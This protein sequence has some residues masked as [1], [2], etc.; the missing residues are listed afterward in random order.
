MPDLKPIFEPPNEQWNPIFPANFYSVNMDAARKAT[1]WR[2]DWVTAT[3]YSV[4]DGI[5]IPSTNTNY[6]CAIAHTSGTFAT[7]LAAVKWVARHL[8]SEWYGRVASIM[9]Q[10]ISA[11]FSADRTKYDTCIG[12]QCFSTP[13]GANVAR[14]TAPEYVAEMGTT[15]V[16]PWRWATMSA[17]AKYVKSGYYGTA[18]ETDM[19]TE[20]AT[21]SA[22]RKLELEIEFMT[23]ESN[24]QQQEAW[25][26]V[27]AQMVLWADYL[28]PLGIASDIY[29]GGLETNQN[30]AVGTLG[31]FRNALKFNP[32]CKWL[33]AKHYKFFKSI[34]GDRY[35][36]YMF[37]GLQTWSLRDPDIY[38]AIHPQYDALV[39]IVQGKETFRLITS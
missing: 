31:N 22:G 17:Y 14:F 29:E 4:G 3:A 1:V 30:G 8:Y 37:S 20:W 24:A 27:A 12:V 39:N 6:L 23:Y 35:A 25:D 5:Y 13:G 32:I 38:Y 19:A 7:D 33:T 28:P 11:I 36:H 18:T 2:G 9:F 15:A 34:G 10:A 21:A 16:E 26:G